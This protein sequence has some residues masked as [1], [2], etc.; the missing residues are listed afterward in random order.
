MK[1]TLQDIRNQLADNLR[2]IRKTKGY[3]Q[4]KL[5][6]DAGVDRT[7]ISKIERAVTNPSLDVLLKIANTLDVEVEDLIRKSQ[8][9]T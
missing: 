8:I 6:F 4:E 2:I 1:K 5:A 7:V 9:N 3:A